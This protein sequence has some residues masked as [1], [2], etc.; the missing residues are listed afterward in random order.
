[1]REFSV[2]SPQIDIAGR[3]RAH[4]RRRLMATKR[5]P[6]PAAVAFDFERFLQDL[7]SPDEDT[8]AR[9]VGR[10]CPC[11]LGWDVFQRCMDLVEPLRKDPSPRVRKAA[12]HVF[13]DAFEM[14][15]HGLPTSPQET[16]NEMVARRRAMRW[17]PDEPE[18]E[19]D[20]AKGRGKGRGNRP[21]P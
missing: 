20:R 1:V 10:V 5:D 4:S 21:G 19:A 9:A 15:S 6:Q 16:K 2:G 3:K 12:L 7:R 11:R 13:E 14:E 18:R 8:R 17:Q